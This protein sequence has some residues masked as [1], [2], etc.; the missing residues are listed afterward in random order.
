[1][2]IIHGNR[3]DHIP[4][5]YRRYLANFYRKRLDLWGTPIR[6]EFRGGV[7]PYQP[8]PAAHGRIQSGDHHKKGR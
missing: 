7:N 4:E 1:L 8:S 2:I 3:I 5:T 6:V